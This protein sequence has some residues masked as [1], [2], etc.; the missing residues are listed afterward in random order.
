MNRSTA[1]VGCAGWSLPRDE[2]PHF[3]ESGTHLQRYAARFNAVEIDSSFYRP[4]RHKTYQRWAASVPDD[5]RFAAKLP[6]NITHTRRLR[7]VED[8]LA[9]FLDQVTGLGGKLGCLLVQ[10]PPSLA[11]DR[12]TAQAFFSDFRDRHDGGIACEPRHASWFGDSA[13]ALLKR[14]RIVRVAA[15]PAC[16]PQAATPGGWTDMVYHRWH[17]SPRMYYS[18]YGADELDALANNA[19]AHSAR[20]TQAWCI[21]DNTALGEATRN[22]LGLIA[23]LQNGA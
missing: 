8:A 11:F 4:H 3:P 17:G 22:A 1:C 21:F 18:A 19:S 5:F 23:R 13:D 9:A 2:W 15:D 6:K 12:T 20:G 10:L 7:E 14:H 16:V